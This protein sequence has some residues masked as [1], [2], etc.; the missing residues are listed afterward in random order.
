MLVGVSA[1]VQQLQLQ[2]VERV[3]DRSRP[4]A[5]PA[6]PLQRAADFLQGDQ[7][8]ER[9]DGADAARTPARQRRAEAAGVTIGAKP[10]ARRRRRG[11]AWRPPCRWARP[12]R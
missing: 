2:L 7:G 11:A 9:A 6:A 3:E 1:A 12:A 5:R 8:V 10:P 4:A